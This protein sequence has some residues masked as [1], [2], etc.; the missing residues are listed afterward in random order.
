MTLI[1]I[2]NRLAVIAKLAEV[3]PPPH[4]PVVASAFHDFAQYI[5]SKE[6]MQYANPTLLTAVLR[7][8]RCFVLKMVLAYIG[9][10]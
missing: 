9:T 1:R 3:V 6:L 5:L 7:R 2:S 10:I 8:P 4:V